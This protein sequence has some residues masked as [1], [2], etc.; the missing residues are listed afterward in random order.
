M[1]SLI[2]LSVN[3]SAGESTELRYTCEFLASRLAII[4][5]FIRSGHDTLIGDIPAAKAREAMAAWCLP[6]TDS[7]ASKIL[8]EGMVSGQER[9]ILLSSFLL[10]LTVL[11]GQT[12]KLADLVPKQPPQPL[13]SSRNS[14]SA[15][16]QG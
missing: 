1:I 5:E 12:A 14:T 8:S 6:G 7:G 13:S 2:L 4:D 11:M 15:A 9:G 3:E 16:E 10:Q